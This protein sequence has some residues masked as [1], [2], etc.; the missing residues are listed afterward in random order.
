MLAY[1][2]M[3]FEKHH[4][5][6]NECPG[7]NMHDV[8]LANEWLEMQRLQKHVVRRFPAIVIL[9]IKQRAADIYHA[10]PTHHNGDD[11]ACHVTCA[12]GNDMGSILGV[13][14]TSTVG[15]RRWELDKT[16]WQRQLFVESCKTRF[17]DCCRCVN[18]WMPF[19]SSPLSP[20]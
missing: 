3:D 16:N 12:F 4:S 9:K 7:M 13:Q 19:H 20:G 18:M 15:S 1:V 14:T 17:E 5:P 6:S 2:H 10:W 8:W 11:D